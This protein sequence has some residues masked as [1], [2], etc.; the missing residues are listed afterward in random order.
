MQVQ[1][2]SVRQKYLSKT[3]TLKMH[4]N[5]QRKLLNQR[6][7]ILIKKEKAKQFFKRQK[8][9]FTLVEVVRIKVLVF[10]IKLFTRLH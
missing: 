5:G 9:F 7:L 4:L 1:E 10:G 8:Y 6:N 2:E 3:L